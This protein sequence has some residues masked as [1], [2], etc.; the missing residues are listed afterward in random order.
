VAKGLEDLDDRRLSRS[1][2]T[3]DRHALA[4]LDPQVELLDRD[5]V[6]VTAGEIAD[7][8]GAYGRHPNESP[9]RWL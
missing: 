4:G 6:T 7:F 9:F 5:E 8:D 1:V 2:R 3:E